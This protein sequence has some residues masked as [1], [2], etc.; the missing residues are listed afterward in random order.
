M[1]VVEDV[2]RRQRVHAL[3]FSALWVRRAHHGVGFTT[4]GLAIGKA[5]NFGSI[6]SSFDQWLDGLNVELRN[7]SNDYLLI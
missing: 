1:N 5:G 2:G 4:A 3:V 7:Y 6:E